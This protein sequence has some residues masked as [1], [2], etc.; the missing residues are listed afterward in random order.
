[1]AIRQVTQLNKGK[2]TAGIDGKLVLSNQERFKLEK[3]LSQKAT[4]PLLL[5]YGQ[6]WKHQGLR[7]V[8]IPK[9]NGKTRMLK[10]PTI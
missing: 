5:S 10:I 3:E 1:M 9:P 2:C 6:K 7:Q 4:H 8:P